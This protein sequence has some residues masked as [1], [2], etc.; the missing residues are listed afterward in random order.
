MV[1]L[2]HQQKELIFDHSIG[3]TTEEQTGEAQNLISSNPEAAELY[4]KLKAALIPLDSLEPALCPDELAEGTIFRL[5][6]AA[7]SSQLQLQNLLAK[8]QAKPQ[9]TQRWSWR[10]IGYR[11]ATAAVFM[12]VGGLFISGW[13]TTLRFAR[14]K[15]LENQCQMQQSNIWQG[16]SNYASD[17][18]GQLPSVA[19][20]AGTPWWKVG[21]NSQDNNSNTRHM[22]LLVKNDYVNPANFICP[23]R[24][25]G[26]VIRYDNAKLQQYNDFP[27]RRLITYS[28]QIMCDKSQS[29]YTNGRKVLMADLNP[30]FD[31]IFEIL[32]Q[33]YSTPLNL[34]VTKELLQLNSNNHNRRGQNVLFSDGSVKFKKKRHIGLLKDDIFTL[35]NTTVYRGVEVPSCDTDAFLAP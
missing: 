15:S 11:L 6:N 20:T 8:E 27:D 3:L 16:I 23:G 7:R 29:K 22:W 33:N 10:E 35:Q 25:Q 19:R 13:N 30:L 4:E 2:T 32:P 24:L 5:K 28:L 31:K 34:R 26:R 12:V 14:Q 1:H 21:D 9:G 17:H 18:Q